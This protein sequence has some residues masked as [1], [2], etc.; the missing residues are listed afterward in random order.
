MHQPEG[1]VLSYR[2]PG[3]QVPR[4]Q[5]VSFVLVRKEIGLLSMQ[6]RLILHLN[7][8]SVKK[9]AGLVE[10]TGG[11]RTTNRRGAWGTG[12]AWSNGGTTANMNTR[13][14][15]TEVLGPTC[16][17]TRGQVPEAR[18][19]QPA[20]SPQGPHMQAGTEGNYSAAQGM[21]LRTKAL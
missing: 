14:W 16:C 7:E 12:G 20:P 18:S 6:A 17:A 10:H 1:G 15:G 8:A 4:G 19:S 11:G 13:P 3:G 5:L 2:R 21:R 9:M